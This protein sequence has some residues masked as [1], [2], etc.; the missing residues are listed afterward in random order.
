ML[1]TLDI[2]LVL[3]VAVDLLGV[4]VDPVRLAAHHGAKPADLDLGSRCG[5]A[6]RRQEVDDVLLELGRVEVCRRKTVDVVE[7]LLL[8]LVGELA[9]HSGQRLLEPLLVRG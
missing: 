9:V 4:L 7:Q 8:R 5:V 6:L 3:L 1:E 2:L